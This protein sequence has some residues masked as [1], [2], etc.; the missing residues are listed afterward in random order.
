MILEDWSWV[1]LKIR[2]PKC[3]REIS[4]NI[5]DNTCTFSDVPFPMMTPAMSDLV[6]YMFP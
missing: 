5:I 1:L 2:N 6:V 3:N 4:H